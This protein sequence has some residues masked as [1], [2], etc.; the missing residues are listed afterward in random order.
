LDT[1]RVGVESLVEWR[2]F[3]LTSRDRQTIEDL[4]QA[5]K[6]LS[7]LKRNALLQSVDPALRTEVETLLADNDAARD[8]TVSEEHSRDITAGSSIA[9]GAQLGPYKLEALLGEGGMGTVYRAR[10][11]RLGRTVAIKVLSKEF[12]GDFSLRR[13]F[14]NEA[15]AVSALNPTS[16]CCMT[17]R[18]TAAWISW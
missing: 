15:R 11:T 16:P 7:A 4:Y 2:R 8:C 17:F 10:D 5:A 9:T 3:S 18:A 12:A 13:R 1:S 14:L 6:D